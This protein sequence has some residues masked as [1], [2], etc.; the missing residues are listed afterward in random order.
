MS[1][2]RLGRRLFYTLA[3]RTPTFLY[4]ATA[5]VPGATAGPE[6]GVPARQ[7]PQRTPAEVT[8]TLQSLHKDPASTDT[9]SVL[10]ALRWCLDRGDGDL[11][12]PAYTALRSRGTLDLLTSRDIAG[13]FRATPRTRLS[14]IEGYLNDFKAAG[15][16]VPHESTVAYL[17]SLAIDLQPHRAARVFDDWITGVGSL[18]SPSSSS[19]HPNQPGSTYPFPNF[20]PSAGGSSSSPSSTPVDQSGSGTA[21][22]STVRNGMHA[23]MAAQALGLDRAR[24]L[25]TFWEMMNLSLISEEDEA[26][27]NIL[28]RISQQEGTSRMARGKETSYEQLRAALG[29]DF[30]ES[31]DAASGAGAFWGLKSA[32]PNAHTLQIIQMACSLVGDYEGSRAIHAYALRLMPHFISNPGY[33]AWQVKIPR[34]DGNLSTMSDRESVLLD[35]SAAAWVARDPTLTSL[36][37]PAVMDPLLLASFVEVR[38]DLGSLAGAESMLAG[39]GKRLQFGGRDSFS[40]AEFAASAS[41]SSFSRSLP[42]SARQR[43][44]S[45]VLSYLDPRWAPAEPSLITSLQPARALAQARAISGDVRGA[46]ELTAQALTL[47]QALGEALFL[48]AHFVAEACDVLVASLGFSVH[49]AGQR[50]LAEFILQGPGSEWK[51]TPQVMASVPRSLLPAGLLKRSIPAGSASLSALAWTRSLDG[52]P[53]EA[54]EA[55]EE[56]IRLG[57]EPRSELVLALMEAYALR[58]DGKGVVATFDEYLAHTKHRDFVSETMLRRSNRVP[59]PFYSSSRQLMRT[60][61]GLPV[62]QGSNDRNAAAGGEQKAANAPANQEGAPD[63]RWPRNTQTIPYKRLPGAQVPDL[64]IA[65]AVRGFSSSGATKVAEQVVQMLVDVRRSEI[66]ALSGPR[67]GPFSERRSAGNSDRHS[68]S[69]ETG[70]ASS[71]ETAVGLPPVLNPVHALTLHSLLEARREAGDLPRALELF[72]ELAGIHGQAWRSAGGWLDFERLHAEMV[73]MYGESGNLQGAIGIL[74]FM[75]RTAANDAARSQ[76]EGAMSGIAPRE[77]KHHSMH[78]YGA[79]VDACVSCGMA[80]LQ[81]QAAAKEA[82]DGLAEHSSRKESASSREVKGALAAG[83]HFVREAKSFEVRVPGDSLSRLAN[84]L[85]DA[86]MHDEL[87]MLGQQERWGFL[88]AGMAGAADSVVTTLAKSRMARGRAV[89][90]EEVVAQLVQEGRLKWPMES[91]SETLAIPAERIAPLI[92]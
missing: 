81:R 15:V 65:T 50:S 37:P 77:A 83:L 2:P 34:A 10:I 4:P 14:R 28:S 48:P 16:R 29:N 64:G 46:L 45:V 40:L 76:T 92:V 21:P 52:R 38:G 36:P 59:R 82:T 27:S 61:E 13:L 91:L 6:P 84:A 44:E 63:P 35:Q 68:A 41:P 62:P 51:I 66:Y 39:L 17:E 8:Q 30:G 71:S 47:V 20:E 75:E 54:R 49:R 26:S 88:A 89:N 25:Q 70:S 5:F 86:G 90:A 1:G 33:V 85:L 67:Q 3:E 74:T 32:P 60:T 56:R 72:N 23:V 24:T 18:P 42:S 78:M 55:M 79:L 12:F 43:A 57:H 80:I 9:P 19:G 53:E 11:A 69:P 7:Q 22:P 31:A 58:K 87:E 73:R